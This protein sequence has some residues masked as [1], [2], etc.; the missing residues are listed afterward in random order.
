MQLLEQ[1]AARE[2]AYERERGTMMAGRWA[3]LGGLATET[4]GS[5]VQSRDLRAAKAEA[6]RR[7]DAEQA[8]NQRRY[9]LQERRA[10]AVEAQQQIDREKADARFD[11]GLVMSGPSGVPLSQSQQQT[12]AQVNPGAMVP[13]TRERDE[14]VATEAPAPVPTEELFANTLRRGITGEKRGPAVPLFGGG[15]GTERVTEQYGVGRRQTA[16]EEEQA[17]DN[18]ARTNAARAAAAQL[19]TS[20]AQTDRRFLEQQERQSLT[21]LSTNKRLALS[22]RAADLA[23][24]RYQQT[25]RRLAKAETKGMS[26]SQFR[27]ANALADDFNKASSDF[28]DRT[29]AY[30]GF[31]EAAKS[32]GGAADIALVFGFMKMQDPRS[33]VREGEVA[34]VKNATNVSDRIQGLY[35][36]LLK[37]TIL[38]DQQRAQV[39]KEAQAAY[40][41][42]SLMQNRV[43]KTYTER[44]M[45]AGLDP[46]DVVMDIGVALPTVKVG[47]NLGPT[48]P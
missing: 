23:D 13:L 2:A 8:E 24:K 7:Y 44:A 48:F 3:G 16:A 22:E 25:E 28:S 39:I 41:A 40:A 30:I 31:N 26:D 21:D 37:G 19:V 15:I 36:S 17:A 20:N 38:G 43:T 47:T 14:F 10:A 33:T 34:S 42:A 9:D 35:N 45:R 27:Q 29:N 4:L 18:L 12:L 1:Q 5:L 32:K 46:R 6:Q 11:Y